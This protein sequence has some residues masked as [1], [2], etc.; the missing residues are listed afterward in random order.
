MR[1]TNR[2]TLFALFV[3]VPLALTGILA[4]RYSCSSPVGTPGA[5]IIKSP[6]NFP[7][8]DGKHTLAVQ[9]TPNKTVTYSVTESA[10]GKPVASGDAGSNHQRWFF[11]WDKTGNLWVHSSDIGSDVWIGEG[12]NWTRHP[13]EKGSPHLQNMPP[14]V[15]QG[16]PQSLRRAL[17]L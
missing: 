10:S 8:L 5:G 17:G 12:G 16:L 9:L 4:L 3:L 6:G 1:V 14:E 15:R 11:F 7:S 2:V 13:F